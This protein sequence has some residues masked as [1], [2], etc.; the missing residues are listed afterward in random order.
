MLFYTLDQF[1]RFLSVETILKFRY[2]FQ[3]FYSGLRNG[4]LK[5]LTRN[6]IDF[7]KSTLTVNKNIVKVPDPKTVKLI[8]LL[9]LKQRML[10]WL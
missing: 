2:V 5:G 1:Q 7:N 3:T 8:L 9:S 6:D 10:L 4:E